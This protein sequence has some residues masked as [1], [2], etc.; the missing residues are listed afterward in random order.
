V[1]GTVIQQLAFVCVVFTATLPSKMVF[2][3]YAFILSG[4]GQDRCRRNV[5]TILAGT[6]RKRAASPTGDT[7]LLLL[8]FPSSCCIMVV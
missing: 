8:L 3:I 7:F 6:A 2:F 5:F 1:L 4:K